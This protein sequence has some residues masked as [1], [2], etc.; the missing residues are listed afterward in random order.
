MQI[1]KKALMLLYLVVV[2]LGQFF[3]ILSLFSYMQ[4]SMATVIV[5]M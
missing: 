2:I 1:I 5:N 3:T 4:K